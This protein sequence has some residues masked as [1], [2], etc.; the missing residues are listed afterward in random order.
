MYVYLDKYSKIYR[1]INKFKVFEILYIL[2][3][4]YLLCWIFFEFCFN[5]VSI[6]EFDFFKEY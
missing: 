4:N 6:L 2:V 5:K 3:L 1:Y